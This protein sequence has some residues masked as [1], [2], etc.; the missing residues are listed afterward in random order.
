MS[1]PLHSFTDSPE[2]PTTRRLS[3]VLETPAASPES[4]A[5]YFAEKLAHECDPSDL[6]ADLE[7]GVGGFVVVDARS[8][9][10]FAQGHIPGAINLPHRTI[11]AETLAPF[12]RDTIFVT[13]CTGPN[14]NGSNKAATRI[15]RLG[16][17]VKEMIGGFEY[18]RREG[19]PVEREEGRNR[20]P[21]DLE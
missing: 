16:Y 1:T 9:E 8:P 11:T 7:S 5:R 21:V 2:S 10:H 20:R 14:C 12:P 4:A 18:W 6:N 15:G 13:Y 19:H 17:R 3:Y